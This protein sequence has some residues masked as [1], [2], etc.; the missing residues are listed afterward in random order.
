MMAF[1]KVPCAID[2]FANKLP[3]HGRTRSEWLRVLEEAIKHFKAD[4]SFKEKNLD[5]MDKTYRYHRA[6]VA[7]GIETT[8]GLLYMRKQLVTKYR[9]EAAFEAARTYQPG[10]VNSSIEDIAKQIQKKP[11]Q[12]GGDDY[13]RTHCI[14]TL[15]TAI[16]KST[17]IAEGDTHLKMSR[18]LDTVRPWL[19]PG[20]MGNLQWQQN[21]GSCV[22]AVVCY[23]CSVLQMCKCTS[24]I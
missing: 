19:Y 6:S 3:C 1:M 14:R 10:W 13:K 7:N 20:C 16:G 8:T 5:E 9:N 21:S 23:R 22:S 18:T 17:P 4:R 24:C 12:L 2:Y 11:M 15:S